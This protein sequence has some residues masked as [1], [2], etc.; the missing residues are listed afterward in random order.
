M[1]NAFSDI[2]VLDLSASLSGAFA[3]RFFGDFGAEVIL[4]ES[5][6]GHTL[7][8]SKVLHAYANWNKKSIQFDG[9]DELDALIKSSDIIITTEIDKEDEL[10]VRVSEKRLRKSV[11]LSITPHGLDGN[12]AG[13]PGNG[14]TASARTGFSHI[15]VYENEPPLQLPVNLTGFIAGVCGFITSAAVAL[16]MRSSGLGDLVDVS[17]VESLSLASAPWAIQAIYENRGWSRGVLGGKA[18]GVPAPLWEAKDGLIN[19]GLG[20]FR[21]WTESMR[22]LGVEEYADN[23]ELIPDIGRHGNPQLAEVV[24]AVAQTV[25]SKNR[26]DLFLALCKLRSITGMVQDMSDIESCDHLNARDYFRSTRIGDKLVKFPGP[27]AHLYPIKWELRSDAPSLDQDREQIDLKRTPTEIKNP[28]SASLS[29]DGPL[30]GKKV[31]A[32]THAWSGTF[33]TELLGLL[34]ADV[35]QIEAPHRVDVWRRVSN[36]VPEGVQNTD[37]DQHFL[38]TQGLY[39][40]ANLNKRA[41]TLDMRT[42]EGQDIFWQLVPH[43]DIVMDNFTPQILPRWGITLETLAEKRPGVVFAS[44]SAYGATGPYQ[45]FPGNGGTTEPMSGLSSIHGYEGD[46]GMNT[47]GMIPDPI[48][49]YFTIA[50]VIAALHEA[51]KTGEAQRIEGSMLESLTAI[52]GD[53]LGEYQLSGEIPRPH[54]NKHPEIAPHGVYQT[55]DSEWIAISADNETA[56]NNFSNLLGLTED[57]QFTSQQQRKENESLLN[58]IISKWAEGHSAQ[59]MENQ[60]TGVGVCAAQVAEPYKIYSEPD[61]NFLSRDFLSYIKHP[62]TGINVLPT[63]AWKFESIES[64]KVRP[65]PCVGQHSKEVLQEYLNITDEKYQKLIEN[66]VTGTIYDYERYKKI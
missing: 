55:K 62:E 6:A 54:G 41:M 60:L 17:E 25:P 29:P 30:A 13:V 16:H 24:A 12:L 5:V 44:L 18:R 50:S 43:F 2:R 20:D 42:T 11:H 40:S 46:L 49:G 48:S 1:S 23:P 28:S 53:A 9:H 10:F 59:D 63:R 32:F 57:S 66:A 56:W 65:A 7:R 4:A 61:A 3:A 39:N 45:E 34:G 31:L 37:I 33:A 38:N 26:K 51:S 27:S 64:S 21:N 47:G 14:L 19:F 8:N 58:E 22:V 52:V 36:K 35:V 15:N